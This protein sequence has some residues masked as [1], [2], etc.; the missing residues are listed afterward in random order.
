MSWLRVKFLASYAQL[1]GKLSTDGNVPDFNN[2]N[3]KKVLSN[4]NELYDAG[5]TQKEGDDPWQLFLAGKVLFC[6]EGEWMLND[7]KP[8][9]T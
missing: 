6:P 4:W 8:L 9:W 3:A 5:Y 2:D 7:V 1:G